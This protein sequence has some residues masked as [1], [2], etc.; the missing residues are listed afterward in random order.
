MRRKAQIIW[1]EISVYVYISIGLI[2]YGTG[3]TL[4]MIPYQITSGGVTGISSLIF[5][6]TGTIEVQVS[7]LTI[8][9]FLLIAAVK[10]LGWKFCL[11]TIYGVLFLTFYMWAIQ[12]LVEDPV[13][14]A[15]PRLVKDQTFMAVVLGAVLEGIGLSVCFSA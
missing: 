1:E 13:T 3:V 9:A 6:A 12:R 4:F 11:K 14:G 7:Y 15:L 10:I 5:Y 2:I 8:N